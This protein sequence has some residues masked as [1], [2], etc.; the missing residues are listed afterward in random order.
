MRLQD[1]FKTPT[2]AK[3]LDLLLTNPTLRYGQG[4]LARR[5]N[6]DKATMRRA[7]ERLRMLGLIHV[8][9]NPA[10]VGIKAIMFNDETEQGK[11]VLAFYRRIAA[12]RPESRDH[13]HEAENDKVRPSRA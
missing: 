7:I 11:A 6:V 4:D 1:I 3:V 9:V 10:G 2:L 8:D 12:V 5:L 13:E